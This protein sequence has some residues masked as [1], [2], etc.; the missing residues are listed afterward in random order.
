[1]EQATGQTLRE[2]KDHALSH[3]VVEL[4]HDEVDLPGGFMR[5]RACVGASVRVR[6]RVYVCVC[7]S[8]CVCVCV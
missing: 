8:V 2:R 3:A 6:V 1:M 4:G 5:V 7:V